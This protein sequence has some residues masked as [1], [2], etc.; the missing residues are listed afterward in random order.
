[1][2]HSPAG[3]YI[4]DLGVFDHKKLKSCTTTIGLQVWVLHMFKNVS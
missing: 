4:A 1:M 2:I 3:V